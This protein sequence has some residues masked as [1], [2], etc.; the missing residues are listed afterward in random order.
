MTTKTNA[1]RYGL[2]VHCIAVM[3]SYG[4][5]RETQAFAF[6]WAAAG[7]AGS[8]LGWFVGSG[9]WRALGGDLVAALVGIVCL[10]FGVL[11][12]LVALNK[13][14]ELELMVAAALGVPVGVWLALWVARRR[15]P[16]TESSMRS[17]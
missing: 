13:L 17:V 6:A 10:L 2:I 12:P 5:L 11:L 14:A 7:L 1:G 8:A 16:A 4:L 3:I 9:E 15:S